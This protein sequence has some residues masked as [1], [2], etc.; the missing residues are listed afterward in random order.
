VHFNFAIARKNYFS[1]LSSKRIFCGILISQFFLLDRETAK[2]SYNKVFSRTSLNASRCST[3]E[4]TTSK[5][6]NV[7]LEMKARKYS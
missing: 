6:L 1:W 5:P 2:F 7:F 3:T 4:T